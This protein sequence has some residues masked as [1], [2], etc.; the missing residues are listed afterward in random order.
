MSGGGEGMVALVALRKGPEG[1]TLAADRDARGAWRIAEAVHEAGAPNIATSHL[2]VVEGIASAAT[3]G[4]AATATAEGSLDFMRERAVALRSVGAGGL[5]ARAPLEGD[6]VPGAVPLRGFDAT[7]SADAQW[8]FVS[9][10]RPGFGEGSAS[11]PLAAQHPPGPYG[12]FVNRMRPDVK[13]GAVDVIAAVA[14]AGLPAAAPTPIVAPTVA[15]SELE[16]LATD[17]EALA[18]RLRRAAGARCASPPH[19]AVLGMGAGSP[20]PAASAAPD[21]HPRAAP[22]TGSPW[23]AGRTAFLP[24]AGAAEGTPPPPESAAGVRSPSPDTPPP[25][26]SLPL[27]IPVPMPGPM[28]HGGMSAAALAQIRAGVTLRRVNASCEGEAGS[29][30]LPNHIP[31]R[32]R[33]ATSHFTSEGLVGARISLSTPHRTAAEASPDA[34]RTK[35]DAARGGVGGVG[36]GGWEAGKAGMEMGTGAAAGAGLM[37]ALKRTLRERRESLSGAAHGSPA[38]DWESSTGAWSPASATTTLGMA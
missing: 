35:A 8:V 19:P 37:T 27:P 21:H 24:T 2:F 9:F 25:A 23:L 17:A 38:S 33:D 13:L 15:S 36:V 12:T 5:L 11:A 16:A 14:H 10:A 7:A 4:R 6:G 28:P 3:D 34:A 20:A 26:H 29:P 1:R 22:R 32:P 30:S 18:C 31:N